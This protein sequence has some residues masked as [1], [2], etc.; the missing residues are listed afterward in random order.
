MNHYWVEQNKF[1]A[2]EYPRNMDHESSQ[3]R[4]DALLELGVTAFVDLTHEDDGMEPYT[5]LFDGRDITYRRF[6]VRDYSVPASGAWTREILDAIDEY[7][8]N[9]RIVYVHCRGGVGR[10]GTIVGCWL[11]RHGY[12]GESALPRL[13]D[14]WSS[15]PK[16]ARQPSPETSEQAQYIVDWN[17]SDT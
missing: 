9:G 7:I 1:L 10:T 6:P 5:H 2:G 8:E 17:E 16:S 13:Q 14:L 15:N 12:P 3:A 4:I 11:S